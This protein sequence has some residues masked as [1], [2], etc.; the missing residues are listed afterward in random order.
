MGKGE[1]R[2]TVCPARIGWAPMVVA[3]A[4][5]LSSAAARERAISTAE[6]LLGATCSEPPPGVVRPAALSGVG[7]AVGAAET[8]AGARD[9]MGAV[10]PPGA[11]C[12]G[13]ETRAGSPNE[14][15][16]EG[17]RMVLGGDRYGSAGTPTERTRRVSA[18]PG[19]M[20]GG[21]PSK[22]AAWLAGL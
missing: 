3:L 8:R 1:A 4:A 15:V 6:P 7:G 18:L 12:P 19:A 13:L 11:A 17:L 14:A 10:W 5:V 2:G 9:G 21:R 16:V 20:R 22:G